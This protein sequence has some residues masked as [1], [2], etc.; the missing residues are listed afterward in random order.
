M[1]TLFQK[2]ATGG[3][4]RQV[5]ITEGEEGVRWRGSA[6]GDFDEEMKKALETREEQLPKDAVP[7]VR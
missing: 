2:I 7:P 4:S 5:G 3:F 1:F 6:K